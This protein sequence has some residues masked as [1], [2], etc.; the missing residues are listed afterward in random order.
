MSEHTEISWCDHTFNPWWGCAKVSAA[1]KNCYAEALDKRGMLG[2]GGHWGV[3][4]PRQFFKDEHWDKPLAW[5]R[6]AAHP[7]LGPEHRPRVFCASMADVFEDRPDLVPHRERLFRLIEACQNLDWILL[8][9]RPENFST[10]LPWFDRGKQIAYPWRNVWLGVTAED[11]ECAE[12]RIPLLRATPAAIRLVSCEPILEHIGEDTW[13]L[14]LG[15][16][17]GFE[18]VHWLIVGDE[19]GHGARPA[20]VDWIRTARDAALNHGL[21]FH[22]KQWAGT[23]HRPAPLGIRDH[24]QSIF[25]SNQR[26][27]IHLPMLDGRSWAEFPTG[28]NGR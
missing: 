17:P 18:P 20:E 25:D 24:N 7:I 16:R 22:F 8:T 1:C 14:A 3:H 10:M 13:D 19:S 28:I 4:A 11:N 5:N 15:F 2:G 23:Q 9:K 27:K 21:S 12:L 26:R 6:K